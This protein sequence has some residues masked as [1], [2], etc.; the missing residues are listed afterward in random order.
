MAIG[1][2]GIAKDPTAAG[3]APPWPAATT[4]TIAPRPRRPDPAPA[5]RSPMPNWQERITRETQ[6]AIRVEH[7]LR[8]RMAAEAIRE[9]AAWCDLGCGNGIAAAQALGG[10]ID[11]RALLV[12][13]AQEA[14]EAAARE[15]QAGEV[16][17]LTADL[18]ST[19]DLA[20]VRAALLEGPRK[21][22]RTV[23]CFEVIE[24]LATFVPLL[25]LLV[26]LSQK[27]GV[28][29]FISVPND[30]FWAIE[31]PHHR[32]AWGEGAFD[33]L[34]RLL[35]EGHVLARQVALQ[36]SCVVR[37]SG[38]DPSAYDLRVEVPAAGVPTHFLAAFGPRAGTLAGG[39]AATAVDLCEQRRWERQR[40]SDLAYFQALQ[41]ELEELRA[42]ARGATRQFDEWR[43]YIHDLERRLGL[44]PSGGEPPATAGANGAT[45]APQ[46][47]APADAE[48][49][50]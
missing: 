10:K 31:N 13:V 27:H 35:P 34:R 24:H 23:T 47:P 15:V 21:T 46:I 12:D 41:G 26:E 42:Y 49:E 28:T 6:P 5:P 9:S 43:A 44:P 32:T 39:A 14:V 29:A 19:E 50:A 25:E 45:P 18:T 1:D 11:G 30:A 48:A 33:E 7:D 40:E 8:Y 16:V 37:D 20:R 2:G 38:K 22:A 3:G 36:G 17:P 4:S